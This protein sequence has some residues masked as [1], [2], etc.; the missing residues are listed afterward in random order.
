MT[1]TR[2]LDGRSAVIPSAIGTPAYLYSDI[3][4]PKSKADEKL[5]I[6]NKT[7]ND[8]PTRERRP[9]NV[10]CNTSTERVLTS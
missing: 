5:S 3:F 1:R 7:K 2:V 4:F 6:K 10:A 9:A 8:A